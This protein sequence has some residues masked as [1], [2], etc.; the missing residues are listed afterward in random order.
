M[1]VSSAICKTLAPIALSP[2]AAADRLLTLER[3]LLPRL[4]DGSI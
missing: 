4:A 1:Y 3:S 2:A